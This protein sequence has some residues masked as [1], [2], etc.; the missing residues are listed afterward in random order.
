M[1]VLDILCWGCIV[2]SMVT[3]GLQVKEAFAPVEKYSI[4][5]Q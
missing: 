5:K 1:I 2:T 3:L 4:F